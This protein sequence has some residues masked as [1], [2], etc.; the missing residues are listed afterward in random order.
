MRSSK[1]L[2]SPGN[3]NVN[4]LVQDHQNQIKSVISLLGIEENNVQDT[5]R[6]NNTSNTSSSSVII[7]LSSGDHDLVGP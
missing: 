2:I 7:P 5:I 1:K 4:Y 6:T 3:M